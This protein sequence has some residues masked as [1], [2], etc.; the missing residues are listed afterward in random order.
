MEMEIV[1]KSLDGARLNEEEIAQLFIVRFFFREGLDPSAQ[2][3]HSPERKE[4]TGWLE[5]SQGQIIEKRSYLI[6]IQ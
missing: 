2:R 5:W 1:S 4:P 6:V 3:Q